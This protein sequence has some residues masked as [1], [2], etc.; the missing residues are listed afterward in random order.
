MVQG[1]IPIFHDLEHSRML[2]IFEDLTEHVQG[3]RRDFLEGWSQCLKEGILVGWVDRDFDV[4]RQARRG[5]GRL[6]CDWKLEG[7]M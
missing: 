4:Y 6:H 7:V 3:L 1:G 2:A 5:G